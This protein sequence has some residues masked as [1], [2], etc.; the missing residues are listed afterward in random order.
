MNSNQLVSIVINNYNY[1]DYLKYSIES[2]LLQEDIPVEVIVIDDGSSDGSK[3]VIDSY[4][5]RIK[6][7]FKENGGQASAFNR[8]NDA[9]K[10]D[11]VCFLDAD[12]YFYPYKA[13]RV[14]EYFEKYPGIEWFFHDLQ[15]VNQNG[16]KIEVEPRVVIESDDNHMW[17][18]LKNDILQGGVLPYLPATSGLCF[19]RKLLKKV[20]PMPEI[21][22]ISAD[23]FLRLS[24][25]YCSPGVLSNEK[26][27]THRIH[28]KNLYVTQLN[29]KAISAKIHMQTAFYFREKHPEAR[30]FANRLYSHSLGRYAGSQGIGKAFEIEEARK[31]L[32]GKLLSSSFWGIL[33]RFGVNYIRAKRHF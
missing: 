15:D 31:Y 17:L 32:S 16:E 2:A 26:L 9:I 5:D 18:D 30:L 20:L 33:G 8:T 14:A 12:D 21:F 25:V 6:P 11:L 4:S 28:G 23:D 1:E 10:G 19:K 13:K 29:K 24:S 27:S 22:R 7:I 3:K